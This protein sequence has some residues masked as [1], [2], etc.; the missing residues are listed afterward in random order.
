MYLKSIEMHGFKS[1]AGRIVLSFDNGITGIVGPNGSGKSNV[2]D[3]VRW[4]LGEQSAKSLRGANMQDVIF[5]GT[6]SRKALSFAYVCLTLDNSD[7]VLPLEYDEVSV[8]RRIYRSGESEYQI[9][10]APCRLKDVQELF[11]DTGIGKE[12]YSI[13]GQGQIER[14]LSSKPE[15]RRELFDEAV[16]IVKYK[17]RKEAS[18]KR[19]EEEEDNLSRIEDVLG[20][21]TERIEPLRRQ[22]EAAKEYLSIKERKKALDINLFL[23]DSERIQREEGEVSSA[24][25]NLKTELSDFEKESNELSEKYTAF[26]DR[27]SELDREIE[28]LRA[29]ERESSEKKGEMNSRIKVLEA[30]INS[31]N[32]LFSN[33]DERKNALIK[34]KEEQEKELS[35]IQKKCEEDERTLREVEN[36]VN[37]AKEYSRSLSEKIQNLTTETEKLNKELLSLKDERINISSE[38]QRFDT[39]IE[40]LSIQKA[41]INKRQLEEGTQE[42]DFKKEAQAAKDR[43]QSL[44]EAHN[45]LLEK[46]EK[47]RE[48][49][50]E[51]E[52]KIE[53][54]RRGAEEKKRELASLRARRETIKN[55]AERYEGYGGAVRHLMA[56]RDSLPG[57]IGVVSDLFTSDSK[58]ETAVETALGGALQNIVTEDDKSAKACVAFLKENRYGRCTFLPVESVRAR[59]SFRFKEALEERGAIGLA[60]TLVRCDEKYLDICEFLLGRILVCDSL[61]NALSIQ[62]K[63]KQAINIV[64]LEGEQL[65]PGGSITGGAYKNSS[66]LLGRNR[67]L[68]DLLDEIKALEDF[69][70]E[71]EAKLSDYIIAKE[72]CED[73]LKTLLGE[74]NES[75]IEVNTASISLQNIEKSLSSLEGKKE[76]LIGE[77]TSIEE[78]LVLFTEKKEE[79]SGRLLEMDQREAEIE[80]RIAELTEELDESTYIEGTATRTLSEVQIEE[81]NAKSEAAHS[82]EIIERLEA[83]I[84]KNA[85]ELLEMD[86]K[87]DGVLEEQAKNKAEIEQIQSTMKESGDSGR[88]LEEEIANL[89]KEREERQRENGT[90]IKE[91]ER[92]DKEKN[93]LEKEDVRLEARAER[94][95]TEKKEAQ[96]K[97]W[98]EYELTRHNAEAYRDEGLS[99][100]DA[101]RTELLDIARRLRNIGSVNIDAIEEYANVSERY[102]FLTGQ[103]EDLKIGRARLLDIIE[104]LNDKMQEKFNSGFIE[105]QKEFNR[106]F[107]ELFGGGEGRLELA[108][109]KDVL[110]S[111]IRIVAQPPGKKLINMMQLSGGEK[112]LTAIALLFSILSLKPS[113]FCLLDEIEAALDEPNVDRFAKYLNRL[114]DYTQFIIITHRRGTMN[115]ADRLYGITM[116]EKGISA[117]VSVNLIEDELD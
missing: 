50:R 95:S 16:G 52:T 26:S 19:L 81:A 49:L 73:E 98:D 111:G 51:F 31:A 100:I 110:E 32:S 8:S 18:L 48:K 74:K 113:P 42:E 67:E 101:M 72:L 9:N 41:T 34:E 77:K 60:S 112:S 6:E 76:G 47:A 107:K 57:V 56:A 28:D 59:D 105:I 84:Q 25:E 20:E 64:T 27:L 99:D 17:K 80:K 75:A 61:D 38:R 71:S 104:E 85:T 65:R 13:I 5:S 91:M 22:S 116:Q 44:L 3:A 39:Q 43:H 90:F 96:E 10:K 12:G 87:K 37:S 4:V 78:N 102:E 14:I 97:I 89:I 86:S 58:Y 54:K 108:D 55:M 29:K 115:A 114:T 94:L 109:S 79:A 23:V 2:S 40:Q 1:F 36:R 66:N 46:E 53:D 35:Q 24:R 30:K 11:Y 92:L 93:N 63:Y 45:I 103:C 117:L 68:S 33:F 15:D 7:H 106:V 69:I 62:K 21:L 88:Q 82:K 83:S 70:Q